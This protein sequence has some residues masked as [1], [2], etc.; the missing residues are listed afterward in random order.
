MTAAAPRV[1]ILAPHPD[2][3]V[4]AC[5]LATIRARAAGTPVFVLY[6]TS[7]VPPRRG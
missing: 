6:L 2:D 7:G 3:E 5:G 4:V 1:L